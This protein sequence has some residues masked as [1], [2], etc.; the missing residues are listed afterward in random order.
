MRNLLR[1]I[2]QWVCLRICFR[3]LSLSLPTRLQSLFCGKKINFS[4]IFKRFNLLHIISSS[5]YKNNFVWHSQIYYLW[6]SV[7]SH[8]ITFFHFKFQ[9]NWMKQEEQKTVL[10]IAPHTEL[11]VM[12][13]EYKINSGID[14]EVVDCWR[15]E[16]NAKI[17]SEAQDGN[18]SCNKVLYF[19]QYTALRLWH[20][21][22]FFKSRRTEKANFSFSHLREKAKNG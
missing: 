10:S 6:C 3:F 14:F 21:L 19:Q 1:R 22:L 15:E 13:S 16:V 9:F 2:S 20:I 11:L 8:K 5:L 7:P 17:H 12:A 18:L 4:S